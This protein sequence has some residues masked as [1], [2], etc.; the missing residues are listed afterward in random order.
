MKGQAAI[1]NLKELIELIEKIKK[2]GGEPAVRN[3]LLILA[4]TFV[5]PGELRLAKWDEIDFDNQ[6]WS[7]PGERMKMGRDHLVPLTPAV[8]S[9]FKDI[10]EVRVSDEYV[11]GSTQAKSGV[12]SDMTFN[13]ALRSLG[14]S[15]D[16]HV[17]H[18]FRKSASTILNEEGW[19]YDWIERQLAHV[20]ANRVR[21]IYN[22]ALHRGC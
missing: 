16:V 11:M 6:L 8:I 14:Y 5:R 13:K 20:P 9:L 7:I 3:G 22:K 12:I 21:G 18:G 15:G 17:A 4:H 1:T 10:H 2:Y 19:N